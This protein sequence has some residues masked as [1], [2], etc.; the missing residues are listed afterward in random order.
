[1]GG[2]VVVD[3]TVVDQLVQRW[4][5]E[6]NN[7]RRD[8]IKT[9]GVVPVVT[10]S[11]QPGSLG[12]QLGKLLAHRLGFQC[13]TIEHIEAFADGSEIYSR[14]ESLLDDQF[15]LAL[16]TIVNSIALD[17]SIES[18]FVRHQ[19]RTI[20]CLAELGG[21]V[22][23][24]WAA[25]YVLGPDCGLHIRVHA[26]NPIRAQNAMKESGLPLKEARKLLR[27]MY[28]DGTGF[29]LKFLRND[30]YDETQYDLLLNTGYM[31]VADIVEIAIAAAKAKAASMKRRRAS[32]LS[33]EGAISN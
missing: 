29:F 5:S 25:N 21:V 19:C 11:A 30:V 18:D 1:M 26:P 14:T 9:L 33:P 24:D 8:F 31:D 22:L 3:N 15:R 16:P 20:L 4:E 32:C 6:R 17:P 10:V 13:L 7:G 28:D 2:T 23:M 12:L 27:E